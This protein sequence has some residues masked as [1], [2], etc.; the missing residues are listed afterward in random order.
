MRVKLCA[1]CSYTPEDLI[2]HHDPQ[3]ALYVCAK[4]D[5]SQEVITNKNARRSAISSKS[6]G[7]TKFLSLSKSLAAKLLSPVQP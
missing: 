4:C 7:G 5:G 6:V 2:G 1:R 3:A